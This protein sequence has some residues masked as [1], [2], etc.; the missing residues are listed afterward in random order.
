MDWVH[1]VGLWVYEFVKTAGSMW[2]IELMIRAQILW[3]KKLFSILISIIEY[4]VDSQDLIWWNIFLRS[5]LSPLCCDGRS[6]RVTGGRWHRTLP[7]AVPSPPLIEGALACTTVAKLRWGWVLRHR[8][9][10]LGP[11]VLT[12]VCGERQWRLA[13]VT[14]LG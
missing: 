6:G 5:N 3:S 11:F 10:K 12:L 13:M 9:D 14:W 4:Q 1:C 2:I 8:N 7:M